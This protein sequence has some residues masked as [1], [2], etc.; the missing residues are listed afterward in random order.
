LYAAARGGIPVSVAGNVEQRHREPRGRR[1]RGDAA[2][3][4]ARANHSHLAD[5]HAFSVHRVVA[6]P[7]GIA[8]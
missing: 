7:F 5:P 8:S 4:R 1:Q 3:H 2:S 6:G